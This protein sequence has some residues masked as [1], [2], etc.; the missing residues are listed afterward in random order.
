MDDIYLGPRWVP[1]DES[2][3][4]GYVWKEKITCVCGGQ[5]YE[6]THDA[7]GRGML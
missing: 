3:P 6:W 5:H 2:A 7:K 4:Y 1:N